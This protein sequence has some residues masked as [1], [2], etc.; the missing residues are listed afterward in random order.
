MKGKVGLEEHFAT[1]DTLADS[2]GFLPDDTWPELRGRLIDIHERR[3]AEMDRHGV[4]M[5]VL[6][7]NAPAIQAMPD[8]KRANEIA[9]RANDFLAEQVRKR[10]DR[11]QALAALPMQDPELAAEEL[12]RCVKDL[13]FRAP[14]STASRSSTTPTAWLYYD[15]PQYW[16]VLAGR[17]EARRAVLSAPA[18]SAAEPGQDL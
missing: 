13:G 2:K 4:E 15:L 9:R 18:Q 10:P 12:T 5:M 16:A 6:S 14:W 8:P 17:R 1:E 11:F 3:I 7:L